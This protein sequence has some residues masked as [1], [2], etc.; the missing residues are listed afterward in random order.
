M[1][2]IEIFFQ[3][4]IKLKHQVVSRFKNDTLHQLGFELKYPAISISVGN[5]ELHNYVVIFIEILKC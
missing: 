2:K 3:L 5:T 4:C 1:I